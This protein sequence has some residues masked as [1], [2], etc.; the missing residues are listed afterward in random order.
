MV[1]LFLGTKTSSQGRYLSSTRHLD[2]RV[3]WTIWFI[4]GLIPPNHESQL[5]CRFPST[6]RDETAPRIRRHAL[7]QKGGDGLAL[8]T[9]SGR[10]LLRAVE[11][12]TFLLEPEV[13]ALSSPFFALKSLA[14]GA[15]LPAFS[16]RACG[17]RLSWEALRL[18]LC[19][20]DA[21]LGMEV[22]AMRG[23]FLA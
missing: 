7:E 4:S 6:A 9:E 3:N 14:I 1:K 8:N 15:E 2:R 13:A 19:D 22:V 18:S 12:Q 16:S 20:V 5:L 23:V 17:L 10:K 21:F 11:E